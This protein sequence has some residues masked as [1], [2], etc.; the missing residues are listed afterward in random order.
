MKA[1]KQELLEKLKQMKTMAVDALESN[2]ELMAVETKEIFDVIELV[3]QLF[4]AECKPG[5][6]LRRAD[7]TIEVEETK[8]V[9]IQFVVPDEDGCTGK[10]YTSINASTD[11][12]MALATMQQRANEKLLKKVGKSLINDLKALLGESED[13]EKK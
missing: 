12:M 7:G 9:S 6:T 1:K 3:Y 8:C 2:E 5:F 10:T 4:D 13:D 11:E